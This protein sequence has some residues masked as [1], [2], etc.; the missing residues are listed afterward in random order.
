MT[1]RGMKEEE[2]KRVA[3]WMKDVYDEVADFDYKET[4]EERKEELKRFRVFIKDNKKIAE[5]RAEIRTL[6]LKFP[7][8]S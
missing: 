7:I 3:K 4:K 5:I 2:M 1:M 8:Y 6:C